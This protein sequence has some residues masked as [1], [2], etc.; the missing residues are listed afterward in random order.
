MLKRPTEKMSACSK[1]PTPEKTQHSA[2]T[3]QHF[4]SIC[5]EIVRPL[6]EQSSL[7]CGD[8]STADDIEAQTIGGPRMTIRQ[9]SSIVPAV[10]YVAG[11]LIVNAHLGKHG[12]SERLFLRIRPKACVS[13]QTA[14]PAVS[15]RKIGLMAVPGRL[16]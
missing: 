6:T 13:P 3:G 7:L 10:V 9:T 5:A 2:N 15:G 8:E 12:I 1:P 16:G 4:R 14:R 11:F